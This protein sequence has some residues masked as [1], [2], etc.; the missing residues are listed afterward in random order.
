M[1]SRKE[2]SGFEKID[3]FLCKTT[4]FDGKLVAEGTVRID[5]KLSGEINLKG[6]LLIGEEGQVQANVSA[7]NLLV[8]GE[9]KGSVAAAG[10]V[11]ITSSGKLF[12]D[13]S[14]VHLIIDEGAVFEGNCQMH[15]EAGGDIRKGKAGG[16]E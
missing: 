13:I 1:F 6:D 4:S 8:A 7:R 9:L 2:A 3:T 5:G 16:K 12:G 14:V 11:E 10:R 15:K